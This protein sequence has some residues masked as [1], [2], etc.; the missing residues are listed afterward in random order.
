MKI[1]IVIAAILAG[2]LLATGLFVSQT[3]TLAQKQQ[4]YQLENAKAT[5]EKLLASRYQQ[6]QQ[7]LGAF[8]H[9]VAG[10]Q[11][12]SMKLVAEQD[13]SAAEVSE[14]CQRYLLP[15]GFSLLRVVDSVDIMLSCG[16]FPAAAGNPVPITIAELDSQPVF[17]MD[18]LHN[19]SVLSLQ[20]RITLSIAEIV[21]LACI[22]GV[23]VDETFLSSLAPQPGVRLVLRYGDKIVGAGISTI[24]S[25]TGNTMA[26][27]DTTCLAA[28]IN[29]PYAGNGEPPILYIVMNPVRKNTIKLL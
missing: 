10:D 22:G 3:H 9:T 21:P 5:V 7:Q 18:N 23:V 15:M 29:L 11:D 2:F 17:V 6:I 4:L 24:S 19:D 25:L 16:Q 26:V 27:N 28:S 13:R 12:F 14:I 8:A 1:V 20:A